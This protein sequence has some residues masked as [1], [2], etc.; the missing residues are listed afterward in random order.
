MLCTSEPR[1]LVLDELL[2]EGLAPIGYSGWRMCL[3]LP[4]V[5]VLKTKPG[6]IARWRDKVRNV[7][8]VFIAVMFLVSSLEEVWLPQSAPLVVSLPSC[9]TPLLLPVQQPL[10]GLFFLPPLFMLLGAPLS[11]LF[12]SVAGQLTVRL[13]PEAELDPPDDF[14][15]TT[16]PVPVILAVISP[17]VPLSTDII[18]SAL[19]A[20]SGPPPGASVCLLLIFCMVTLA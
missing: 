16:G 13:I 15:F 12:G 20:A 5:C 11:L 7:V 8:K 6:A 18:G 1:E 4:P 9:L 10:L 19:A 14:V 17:V 3:L 2:A